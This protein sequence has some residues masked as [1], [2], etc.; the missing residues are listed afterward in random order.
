MYARKTVDGQDIDMTG[1]RTLGQDVQ[2]PRRHLEP[3][4][5]AEDSRKAARIILEL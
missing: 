2:A 5:S 1:S 3:L 4:A